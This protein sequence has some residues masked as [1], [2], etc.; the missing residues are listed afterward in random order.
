[1]LRDAFVARGPLPAH[2]ALVD[3]VMT[4]GATLHAAAKAL[5]KAGVQRVDAWVCARVP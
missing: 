3:D 2:V 5:R 4:T 1:N